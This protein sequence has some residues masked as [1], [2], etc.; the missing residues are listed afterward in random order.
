MW[1][2]LIIT[3]VLVQ[4]L[5]GECDVCQ[6]GRAACHSE[7]TY[8]ICVNGK[9][10]NKVITCPTNYVCTGEK[11]ICYPESHYDPICKPVVDL[12][13]YCTATGKPDNYVNKDDP[14]CKTF[15]YC[16]KNGATGLLQGEIYECSTKKPYFNGTGCDSVKPDFCT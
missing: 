5:N 14:T 9:A 11:Y 7:N 2:R 10:S 1:V 4:Y 3:L 13:A 15:I 6:V 16:F 8:S 12:D